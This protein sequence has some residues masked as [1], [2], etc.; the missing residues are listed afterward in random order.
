MLFCECKKIQMHNVEYFPLD[1][2]INVLLVYFKLRLYSN[3][4]VSGSIAF[5]T[6]FFMAKFEILALLDETSETYGGYHCNVYARCIHH[7]THGTSSSRNT[8]KSSKPSKKKKIVP[9]LSPPP[10]HTL[11]RDIVELT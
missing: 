4:F 10:K 3:I 1:M 5:I 9:L 2:E 7:H 11:M 6:F 8:N